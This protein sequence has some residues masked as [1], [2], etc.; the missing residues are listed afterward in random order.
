[1]SASWESMPAVD[2]VRDR[3]TSTQPKLAPRTTRA[4]VAPNNDTRLANKPSKTDIIKDS[5][6]NIKS[7]EAA[8]KWLTKHDIIIPGEN[9]TTSTLTMALFYLAN[10]R[11]NTP[12]QLVNGI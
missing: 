7:I 10:G 2:T 9:L 12:S 3:P 4:T 11:I 1:M 5:Q 6:L 8:K